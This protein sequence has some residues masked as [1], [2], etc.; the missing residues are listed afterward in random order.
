[1][2]FSLFMARLVN[3]LLTAFSQYR[4]DVLDNEDF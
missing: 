1:M 2:L 3:V 4:Y